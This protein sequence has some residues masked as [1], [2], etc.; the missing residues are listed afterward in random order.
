[1]IILLLPASTRIDVSMS[2]SSSFTSAWAFGLGRNEV[3][4][5]RPVCWAWAL[6]APSSSCTLVCMVLPTNIPINI[7]VGVVHSHWMVPCIHLTRIKSTSTWNL[8]VRVRSLSLNFN[9]SLYI[10]ICQ[11]S[12]RSCFPS[13][14]EAPEEPVTPAA[15]P[16]ESACSAHVACPKF[17]GWTWGIRVKP[18]KTC[19]DY[20]SD[21]FFP[22]CCDVF[23]PRKLQNLRHNVR[24]SKGNAVLLTLGFWWAVVTWWSTTGGRGV[25]NFSSFVTTNNFWSISEEIDLVV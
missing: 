5:A 15:A 9:P 11:R 3:K 19:R 8:L 24:V 1:M 13:R 2:T 21:M 25:R 23:M 10:V 12:L 20:D 16:Y 22:F 18:Q 7:I 14:G 4:E 6:W 17:D